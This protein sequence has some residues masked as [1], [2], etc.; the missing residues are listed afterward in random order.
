MRFVKFIPLFVFIVCAILLLSSIFMVDTTVEDEFV[1]GKMRWFHWAVFS[2]SVSSLCYIIC[3]KENKSFSFST[4]DGLIIAYISVIMATYNWQLNPV[5]EKILFMTQ[6]LVLWFLLRFIFM[7]I[8]ILHLYFIGAIIIVGTIESILGILQLN[9]FILSNHALF[10]VTGDFYNPGP[11]SGFLA[12]ILPLCLWS[13]LKFKTY[14]TKNWLRIEAYLY[15]L[16]WIGL[17]TIVV[18][19][20]AGMSRT[21]WIATFVSCAWVYWEECLGW[22]KTKSFFK[23]YHILSISALLAG[24]ILIVGISIFMYQFKQASADG[25]FFLWKITTNALMEHPLRGVGMGGFRAAYADAQAKYFASGEGTL[26]EMMI[27]G[28][29][30]SAFNEFLHMGLEQGFLGLILFVALLYVSLCQ[31]IRNKQTGVVAS[32]FALIV[33]SLA[34]YPLQL[35]EFWIVL[36]VLLGIVNM[37]CIP[38][39]P[40][41]KNT[42]TFLI[43]ISVLV[44]CSG[45]LVKQN[46][47]FYKSY[48]EWHRLKVL[49]N[50]QMFEE[51]DKG[52]E[53]LA[54]QMKHRPELLFETASCLIRNGK[55]SEANKLL[56]DAMKLTNDPLIYY[57]SA[58]NEQILGNYSKAEELLLYAANMLPERIYPYYMLLKLYFV[59]G[60]VEK[61]KLINTANVI[62]SKEVKVP[63]KAVNEMKEYAKEI[64]DSLHVN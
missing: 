20:P 64:L 4:A 50:R 56:Y 3:V 19:M 31:G 16:A 37:T 47:N 12:I 21:A 17:L 58:S 57:V 39:K 23:K 25:R 13:I 36:I 55:H 6:L 38:V 49:N 1:T 15:Y 45:C 44:L 43:T 9:G 53:S 51:S 2:L 18:V 46:E 48:K 52:Y 34:S 59:S 61:N 54:T 11:F 22:Q 14:K 29:P 40:I 63:S 33:F 62:L 10:N 28:C 30:D 24:C 8:R 60:A 42:K 41:C 35:L 7:Q 32:L 26:T 27:A 5:P